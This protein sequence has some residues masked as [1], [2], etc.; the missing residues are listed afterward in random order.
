MT[1]MRFER[2]AA[3]AMVA[4]CMGAINASAQITTGTVAGTVKDAQG[5]VVPGATVVLISQARGTRTAPAVTNAQGDYVI[6]NV[7]ADTYTV[8]VTMEG[9]KTIKRSDIAVSGGDRVAI[10][11][12]TLEVG[13]A[14]ETV[15]VSAEAPLVQ[16]QSGERSFAVTTEQ[17]ENLPIARGNFT[18]LTRSPPASCRAARAAGRPRR[19]WRR[20]QPEQHH[21]GRR[22]RDG[23]RQQ[24]PDAQHEH[25]VHRRGQGPHP[26]LSGRVRPL[27][28]SADH[29]RHEE[30][31]EPVPRFRL[32]RLH[33]LRLEQND[34][35][36]RRRTATRS[37]RPIRRPRLHPRR[38]GRQAR[39]CATS[40]SSSTR[41]STGRRR[42]RSTA[43]TPSGSA[44][45]PR[46]SAP[47]TS[48]RACDNNGDP[49]PGADRLSDAARTFAGNRIIPANRLYTPGLA[50]LNR[51][52]LPNVTQ[53]AGTNYNYQVQARP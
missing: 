21:D 50:V 25:R 41:T 3:L 16:S 17:I 52:P 18:S 15:N 33:R 47:A 4:L 43:A 40:C 36:P 22:V 35:G 10:P 38:P 29:R 27:E 28:R 1:R 31:H 45:R 24:R 6:A 2:V 26:G 13:G 11:A 32:Q 37:R 39:R 53:A 42:P 51:Y 19:H 12:L 20:R 5:G 48:R 9:F 46:S 8:E 44:C 23:H 34:V 7:T 14:A 49:D 30:R